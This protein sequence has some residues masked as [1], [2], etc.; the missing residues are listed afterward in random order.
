MCMLFCIMY[1]PPRAPAATPRFDLFLDSHQSMHVCMHAVPLPLPPFCL[2]LLL[3]VGWCHIRPTYLSTYM[4]L[5]IRSHVPAPSGL[6]PPLSPPPP[7]ADAPIRARAQMTSVRACVP[8]EM[9]ST[10]RVHHHLPFSICVYTSQPAAHTRARDVTQGINVSDDN[11]HSVSPLV[12]QSNTLPTTTT[13]FLCFW[14]SHSMPTCVVCTGRSS[15]SSSSMQALASGR[16]DGR[17]GKEG[18]GQ[19]ASQPGTYVPEPGK[20]AWLVR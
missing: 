16:R 3:V 12:S 11:T 6:C 15:R 18:W 19:P 7:A 17:E 9:Y 5:A 10:V 1:T 2:C 13:H 8:V 14:V 20:G 4:Y